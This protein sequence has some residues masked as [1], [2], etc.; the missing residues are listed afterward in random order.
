[1]KLKDLFFVGN[2]RQVMFSTL[3][4]CGSLNINGQ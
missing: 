1:M 4:A 2:I 3:S